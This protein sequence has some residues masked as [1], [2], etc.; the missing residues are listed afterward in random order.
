[1]QKIVVWLCL[2]AIIVIVVLGV[3]YEPYTATPNSTISLG[4]GISICQTSDLLAQN[5]TFSANDRLAQSIIANPINSPSKPIVTAYR[6]AY[7]S[8]LAAFNT[9]P[10][11]AIDSLVYDSSNNAIICPPTAPIPYKN[12]NNKVMCSAKDIVTKYDCIQTPWS[13]PSA[14]SV[15]C[16]GGTQTQ[17]RTT[18]F[19]SINGGAACGALSQTSACN[20]QL[21]P[22]N[23]IGSWTPWSPCSS[24]CG[25]GG[26]QTQT[27]VVT[28]PSANGGTPCTAKTGDIVS[29]TC[30]TPCKPFSLNGGKWMSSTNNVV[31]F[32]FSASIA[33][34]GTSSYAIQS[35]GH[36]T[37][38]ICS[39]C[40]LV[41]SKLP[42]GSDWNYYSTVSPGLFMDTNGNMTPSV[43]MTFTFNSKTGMID[44]S[45]PNMTTYSL[46]QSK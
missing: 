36:T 2:F 21:C 39:A 34:D 42:D 26:T 22:V 15:E 12:S 16:G 7:A 17:T 29:Q 3:S 8:Y 44:V 41:F 31:K 9:L 11:C 10:T 40:K 35:P 24:N 23:C 5:S 46:V 25:G 1:M 19:D 14:C 4:G 32:W 38:S 18:L 6:N 28:T 30:S 45:G 20:T 27:Y 13:A 33:A 37:W 43:Q